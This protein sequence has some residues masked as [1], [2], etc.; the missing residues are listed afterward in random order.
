MLP[1]HLPRRPDGLCQES[2]QVVFNGSLR[3]TDKRITADKPHLPYD[4]GH[5]TQLSSDILQSIA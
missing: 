5:I 1:S 2:G 4:L 3:E